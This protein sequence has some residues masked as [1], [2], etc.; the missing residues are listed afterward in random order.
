[1]LIL[2][3][4]CYAMLSNGLKGWIPTFLMRTYGWSPAN[5]GVGFGLILLIFGTIGT[6]W[7]GF[8]AIWLRNRGH[9]DANMRLSV[10]AALLILPFGIAAPLM[11]TG[12]LSLALYAIVIFLAGVPFGI[13]A[14]AIQQVTPN[15]M[16]GQVS[17]IYLFWLNLAGI[18]TGPIIVALFTD[19]VFSDDGALRDSL[20]CLV[21]CA[22]PLSA[23][24]F[25]AG[26][27]RLRQLTKEAY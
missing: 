2:G 7:G 8:G 5:V 24:A 17:A 15:R 6:A 23:I 4:S 26:L 20:A 3:I 12:G 19:F 14:A 10:F 9:G 18:G 22:A 11:P 13:S 16:R 1:M 21:A 27:R 25:W